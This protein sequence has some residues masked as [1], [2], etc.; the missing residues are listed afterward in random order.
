M[1]E[2]TAIELNQFI[3]QNPKIILVDV[4]ENW[5]YNVVSIKDSVHIPISEIQNKMLDFDEDQTIAFIC[6]HGVRSRMVGIYFEQNDFKNIINLR[7]GIDS[8]AKTVDKKMPI[9]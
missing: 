6:H 2:M 9:Y 4:R 8:W 7:G 1:I 5:E 3:I